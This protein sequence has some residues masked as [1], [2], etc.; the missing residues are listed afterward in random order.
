M[1]ENKNRKFRVGMLIVF[2]AFVTFLLTLLGV[3]ISFSYGKQVGKYVLVTKT[4]ENENISNELD[5]FRTIIDKYF[6]GKVDENKLREGAIAGYIHGLDDPY[7]EYITKD[8]MKEYL[9]DTKGNFVGIGVYM[10]KDTKKNQII[11][12][13]VIPDSPAEK[14]GLKAGDVI[15]AVDGKDCTA[16]DFDCIS[17]KIKGEEGTIAKLTILRNDETLNLEVKRE[18]VVVNKVEG[19]VIE[20]NIGYIKLAS[21][22]EETAKDFK[23][24]FE[25]LQKQNIKSLIIDLRNNGGGIVN[26]ALKIADYITD[27][28]SVLLYEIDKNEKES[29]K[30]SDHDP[31]INMPIVVL[32]NGN[33]ASSSE[34]LAGAL[35]D[36]GKAEIV[37]ETSYGKGVIQEILSLP[38]GSGLKITTEQYKTPNKNV[39]HKKGIEPDVKVEASDNKEE[40]V[41]LQKAI[42]LLK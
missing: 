29:V 19:K 17:S 28:G 40:D 5:K 14:V 24:K 4:E 20:G 3:F 31:I 2:T 37:G 7:T 22:D 21:F 12:I 1:E 23:N 27:K 30:K 8:K 33:T 38:G 32:I 26:E 42:E 34:I 10:T 16:D 15:K 25:E 11:I 39:I 13:G 41:Q 9:E 18:K 36:L 6:L 35:K